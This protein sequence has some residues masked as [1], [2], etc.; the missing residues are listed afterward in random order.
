MIDHS[1]EWFAENGYHFLVFSQGMYGRLYEQPEKY[2]LEISSYEAL[3][4]RFERL[5][6]F[7][8]GGFQVLIYQVSEP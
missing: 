4:E 1:P 2:S 8:D 3:F 5:K 6:E 7:N